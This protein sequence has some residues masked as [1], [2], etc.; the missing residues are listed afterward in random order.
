[1]K[2]RR[3][4]KY[5]EWKLAGK[6]QTWASAATFPEGTWNFS[7]E[8]KKKRGRG[9]EK[10]WRDGKGREKRPEEKVGKKKGETEREVM[11]IFHQGGGWEEVFNK[12]CGKWGD[13]DTFP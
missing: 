2:L 7:W 11:E 13:G 5:L 4:K 3:M 9:K 12:G 8:Q 10:G 6:H 1:M